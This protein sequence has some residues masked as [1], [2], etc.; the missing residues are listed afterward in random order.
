M[1]ETKKIRVRV[2][3]NV[4]V[5]ARAG[6]KGGAYF[7]PHTHKA[8]LSACGLINGQAYGLMMVRGTWS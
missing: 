2:I 6:V 4:T 8:G 7:P 1:L 3:A 5:R